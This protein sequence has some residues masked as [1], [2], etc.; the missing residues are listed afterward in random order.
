MI[1]TEAVS[2]L[3]AL[4]HEDRLRAFRLLVK[5]GPDGMASGEIAEALDIA[6]TRM[7]FHLA[8][9]ERADLLSTRR[10]GRR[11]IYTVSFDHMRAVLEFL[12]QDCCNGQ[13]EICGGLGSVTD[14]L[15]TRGC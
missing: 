3:S 8:G 1:D 2:A 11:I 13:P 5:A 4:A 6:P 9:L 14:T 12:T 10:D 15:Q 7:S